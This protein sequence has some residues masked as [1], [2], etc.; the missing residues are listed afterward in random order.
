MSPGNTAMS[1]EDNN[2]LHEPELIQVSGSPT[3][4]ML[5]ASYDETY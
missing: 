5:L 3:K 2:S 1:A 4:I